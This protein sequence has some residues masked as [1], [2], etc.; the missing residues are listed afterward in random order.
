MSNSQEMNAANTK[1]VYT[2][3]EIAKILEISRTAAY[4]LVKKGEFEVKW[5]NSTIRISKN[6]FDAWLDGRGN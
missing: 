4:D 1:R 6:S 2:V 3:A 5:V